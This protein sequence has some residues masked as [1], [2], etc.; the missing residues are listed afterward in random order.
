[1]RLDS[2]RQKARGSRIAAVKVLALASYPVEAAATRYRLQ[3][4]VEPLAALGIE[5]TIKPFLSSDS[6]KRLYRERSHLRIAVDLLS[7]TARRV[8]SCMTLGQADVILVQREAMILGPPIIEWLAA[9]VFKR[10][11]VLDLDDATYVPYTSPTYGGLAKALKFFRKT[12]DLIRWSRVVICGNQTVAEYVSSKGARTEIIP[13]VVDTEKFKPAR[14]SNR[15]LPV[16]GWVG[17]HSTFPFMQSILPALSEVAKTQPFKLKIVGAGRADVV[18]PGIEVENLE[19]NLER[20]VE[21][22]QS[23]DVGLYPV[24]ADNNWATGKSGFKAIQYMAT[25]VPYVAT[26][27]GAAA[28]IGEENLTHLFATTR[29]EWIDKLKTL[30]NDP[31]RRHAMGDAGRRHAVECYHLESQAEKLAKVLR[32]AAERI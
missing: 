9:R 32:E 8:G 14:A 25:G 10:P 30:L 7:A 21:D 6:F 29:E 20:E 28:Q 27:I 17:T 4:F 11:M 24:N 18:V 19:W 12:D 3:Q 31:E 2:K 13:T 22:F 15:T 1:M 26:P 23:L 16:V 5:L